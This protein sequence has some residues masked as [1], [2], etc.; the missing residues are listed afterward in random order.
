[1]LAVADRE[2][3]AGEDGRRGGR[4]AEGLDHRGAEGGGVLELAARR[5]EQLVVAEHERPPRRH[6][7]VGRHHHERRRRPLRPARVGAAQRPRG[8]GAEDRPRDGAEA[9]GA[10]LRG[11][12]GREEERGEVEVEVREDVDRHA[13]RR[14]GGG[15][16]R[17]RAGAGE[18]AE[19][20]AHAPARVALELGEQRQRDHAPR[21]AA[22]QAQGVG[23]RAAAAR[24]GGRALEGVVVARHRRAV[25]RGHLDPVRDR[26]RGLAHGVGRQVHG[27]QHAALG[28]QP[29]VR[30][31]ERR[32]EPGRRAQLAH[33]RDE[34]G[35][36]LVAVGI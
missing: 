22:V 34:D 21:P 18:G 35:A 1:M 19:H 7:G 8:G 30:D 26:R 32:F 4:R 11:Q 20:L 13:A 27:Q 17:A 12:A 31:G 33:R 6:A 36:V 15:D 24:P 16:E 28:G 2:V 5:L 3:D 25:G 14:E 23:R 10:L 29:G 9:E